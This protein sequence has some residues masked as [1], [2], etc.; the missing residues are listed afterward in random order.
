MEF[1]LAID[2]LCDYF[3][4]HWEGVQCVTR[5]APN[6]CCAPDWKCNVFW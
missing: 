5:K 6:D 2:K 4:P 1:D 3:V